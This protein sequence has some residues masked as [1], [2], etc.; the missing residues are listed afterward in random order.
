M[1]LLYLKGG[2]L[3]TSRRSV[4]RSGCVRQGGVNEPGSSTPQ[5]P[6]YPTPA[7]CP[8]SNFSFEKRRGSALL[9]FLSFPPPHFVRDGWR[10]ARLPPPCHGRPGLSGFGVEEG[11]ESLGG[12]GATAWRASG[13]QLTGGGGGVRL[14]QARAA[15]AYFAPP[16]RARTPD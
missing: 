11:E 13:M 1:L 10:K 5:P 4:G 14:Q 7:A 9:P 2:T 15:A 3:M 12:G 6:A 8:C 16:P